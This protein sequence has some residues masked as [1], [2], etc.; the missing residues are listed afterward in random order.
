MGADLKMA[1]SGS[2]SD[3][4]SLASLLPLCHSTHKYHFARKREYSDGHPSHFLLQLVGKTDACQSGLIK[5]T[6]DVVRR[7]ACFVVKEIQGCGF[8]VQGSGFRV[9]VA[10]SPQIYMRRC[11]K[12]F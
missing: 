12:I 7:P 6:P 3:I 8:R 1:G 10:A 11:P 9:V 2:I 5:N 4:H